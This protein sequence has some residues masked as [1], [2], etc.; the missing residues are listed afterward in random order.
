MSRQDWDDYFIDIA[1]QISTRSTC[2]RKQVG[3]VIVRDRTI[4]ATG[5][6][7]SLP[8]Q[9][10]CTDYQCFL[11]SGHCIRTIHA[12]TNAIN[13]A[14]KNGISLNGA[15]IYCSLEPCWLCFKN[16]ISS[17]IKYIYFKQTYGV[18]NA[19]YSEYLDTHQITYRNI[20]DER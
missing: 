1:I 17:G 7:G 19:L 11:E 3:C 5:Y 13:Q 14:A 8:G 4:I 2:L 15:S 16:I 10:H 12:E 9:P 18:K 20:S 6:N